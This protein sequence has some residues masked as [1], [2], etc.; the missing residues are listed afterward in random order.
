M[1]ILRE[2]YLVYELFLK[3]MNTNGIVFDIIK[4]KLPIINQEINKILL[5][6]VDFEVFLED[7][8]K[9]L[10]VYIKHPKFNKRSIEGGSRSRK[11]NSVSSN[12]ISIY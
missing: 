12:K 6:I 8:G 4:N 7:D 5:S 1:S 11:V 10:D 3:S 9:K 2:Q